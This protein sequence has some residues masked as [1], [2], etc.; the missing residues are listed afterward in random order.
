MTSSRW[1]GNRCVYGAGEI[2]TRL[3]SLL[4]PLTREIV[5][6]TRTGRYIPGAD[7][8]L[9]AS[10]ATEVWSAVDHVVI[11]APLTDDT[12][13]PVGEQVLSAMNRHSWLVNVGRGPII[14]TISLVAALEA[15]AIAGVALDVTDPEPLPDSHPLWS[16]PRAI[17]TPHIANPSASALARY[18]TLV[19]ENLRRFA[20]GLALR[21]VVDWTLGY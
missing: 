21:G 5:A 11:T 17:V 4:R 8:S 10:H 6:V 9:R 1:T 15:H 20:A 19:T 7:Q 12:Y 3:V 13:H 2:G 18:S 16:N 14:D